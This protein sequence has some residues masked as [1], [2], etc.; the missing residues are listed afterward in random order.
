MQLGDKN[1][2][3]QKKTSTKTRQNTIRKIDDNYG[4]GFQDQIDT[5]YEFSRRFKRDPE[6]TPYNATPFLLKSILRQF[7]AYQIS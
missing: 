3:F 5:S 2:Y 6:V 1:K 4:N 7:I